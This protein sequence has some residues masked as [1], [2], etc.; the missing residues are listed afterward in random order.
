MTGYVSTTEVRVRYAETDQ[1]GFAHHAT[2]LVWCELGRTNH[3]R[4]LGVI[5]RE[6]E[7]LGIRLPVAS[8]RLRFRA[9]AQYD[10]LIQVRSWVRDSR[11]R[12]V[13]F[14]NAIE[15]SNGE[16]LATAEIVVMAID[17]NNAATSLPEAVRRHLVAVPDPVR[18]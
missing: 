15:R 11:S 8:A 1:M 14:G 18:L 10:E 17:S 3:M 2:Y 12:R 13:S 7:E 4:E 9:S 5:Y 6:L 16:L